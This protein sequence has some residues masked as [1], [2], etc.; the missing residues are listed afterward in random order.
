MYRQQIRQYMKEAQVRCDVLKSGGG[1]SLTGAIAKISSCRNEIVALEEDTEETNK[2]RNAAS[3]GQLCSK[4]FEIEA[5][6]SHY[7]QAE[8]ESLILKGLH[9]S[10]GLV[11]DK[12]NQLVE[13]ALRKQQ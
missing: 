5:S 13:K 7:F 11:F 4:I 9:I 2:N 6:H 10:Y 12:F 3:I 1:N 8:R